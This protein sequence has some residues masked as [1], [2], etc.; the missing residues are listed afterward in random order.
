MNPIHFAGLAGL[1]VSGVIHAQPLPI[2]SSSTPLLV[3]ATRSLA[4]GPTLREAVV[5][6]REELDAA[7]SL[8]LGEVLARRAG[9]ELRATGGPGQP[10]GLFIRGAGTAQTL[11]L[12]DGLR[13][14]SATI[15]T[16][17]LENIPLE[18]VER[19]EVV[20]GPLSS[21]YGS[22]AIGG[23]VQVFTRGKGV[24]HLFAAAGVG[25]DRERRLS[26]GFTAAD[27][28]TALTV[29][30]GAR[31]VDAPSATNPRAPFSHD[32][33][34]DPYENAFANV[35][36]SHRLWQGEM[37]TLEAFGS[38]GRTRYDAG[39]PFEGPA[40]DDRN[41]QTLAG[42]RVS[43]TN[44]IMPGWTSRLSLGHGRDRIATHGLFPGEFETRQDQASWINELTTGAGILSAGAETVRQRVGPAGLFTRES[45]RT[46]SVF[47]GLRESWRGH[48]LEAS[49]RGDDDDQFGRHTTGSASYGYEWEGVARASFTWGRGFRAPTFF[50]LYAPA[51]DFYQ[52][53]PDLRPERSESRE[54]SLRSAGTQALRWRVTAYDNR[55]DD[56]IVYVFPTVR[57]V[58][59]AE[60]R[61]VEA[62]VELEALGARWRATGTSQKPRDADTGERLPGR[63]RHFGTLE[64]ERDFGPVRGAL[65]VHASGERY[66]QPGEAARLPGYATLDARVRY[67]L[68]KRWAI[69]VSGTNLANKRRET[70]VGYDAPGRGVLVS[71]RFDA[72]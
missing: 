57:N 41:D 17:S 44:E 56:L 72:F 36:V 59:R 42:A 11:V 58:G 52:S 43:S 33:D 16:T 3:T 55:I 32:P 67:R 12:V 68:D 29:T 34:R 7:G 10:Q 15:G 65:L 9:L 69:E 5:I 23:V 35:R 14:G 61:G 31:E 66:D 25:N 2:V 64:V 21:L 4:A 62:T 71:L 54:V 20:K 40:L 6:T 53:N 19:I 39:L 49:I 30:L 27:A 24:P 26:A 60:I 37:V 18:I 51:T 50:D 38:R 48:R 8:S 28:D 45:R 13:V 70:S 22:D 47:G 63:A 1:A 46:H